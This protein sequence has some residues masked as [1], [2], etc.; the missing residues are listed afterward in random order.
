MMD[1][2][3][4]KLL[5]NAICQLSHWQNREE[6]EQLRNEEGDYTLEGFDRLKCIYIHIPKAA[7]VSINKALF[8]NYGGGHKTVHVYKRIFG[9]VL[10][11]KYFTFTF[12]RNPYPRL[13]SAYNFLKKGGFNN[14]DAAWA[15]ENISEYHTFDEFIE[16]WLDENNIWS[17]IHFKPQYSFVCDI[18]LKPEV[19][20]IGKVEKI[21]KDFDNVCKTLGVENNL[22]VY[23]KGESDH[24]NWKN[25]YTDSSLQKVAEVYQNDFEIFEYSSL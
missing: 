24:S 13:L 15:S 19:D 18:D 25:S 9:P 7:G 16:Q 23:N 17:Y 1:L 5:D 12:V 14:R 11:E 10:F 3:I 4:N 8:G 6:F 21:D 22:S 2:K 20:F